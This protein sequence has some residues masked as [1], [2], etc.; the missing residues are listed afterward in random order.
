MNN[1]NSANKDLVTTIENFY[2]SGLAL[3]ISYIKEN[4]DKGGKPS[5]KPLKYFWKLESNKDLPKSF[6]INEEIKQESEDF[7]ILVEKINSCLEKDNCD[8]I[9][10]LKTFYEEQTKRI[11]L[12]LSHED[13]EL[14]SLYEEYVN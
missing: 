12:L 2:L 10:I 7:E 13:Y 1:Y 3:V 8:T 6:Y 4:I 9:L 11:R 14:S 5:L